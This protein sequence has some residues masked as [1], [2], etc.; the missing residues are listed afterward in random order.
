MP[1]RPPDAHARWAVRIAAFEASG[2]TARAFARAHDLNPSTL[3]WW[4]WRLRREAE[5]ARGAAPRCPA[6]DAI[7]RFAE[8]V[9]ADQPMGLASG[10]VVVNLG[11]VGA[12]IHVDR[13]TDLTLLRDLLE[14]LC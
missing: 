4:R 8:L 14:A 10:G 7:P 1:P 3:A 9:I 2:Q 5:R 13:S 12:T 11:A 6:P